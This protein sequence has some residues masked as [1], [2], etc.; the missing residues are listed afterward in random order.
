MPA[1]R[2]VALVEGL[3]EYWGPHEENTARLMEILACQLEW[4]WADRT[5]DPEDPAV[6]A[7]RARAKRRKPPAHP[8]VAPVA[9]RPK[10]FADERTREYLAELE[11]H[12]PKSAAP[13]TD[14]EKWAAL[15]RWKKRQGIS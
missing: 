9:F 1:T 15:A 7:E 10:R 8:I 3:D 13:E 14:E 12:V 4:D 2:L 11:R 5:I 6:K